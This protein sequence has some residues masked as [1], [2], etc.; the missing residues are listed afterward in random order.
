MATEVFVVANKNTHLAT[1]HFS[2]GKVQGNTGCNYF[3]A[4]Y[5][6]N[7]QELRFGLPRTTRKVCAE[8]GYMEQEQ[9][10][11]QALVNTARYELKA[12]KL[13]LRDNKGSL[14]V[15]FQ[16]QKE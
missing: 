1:I 10:Y 13:N 9:Q 8:D 5:E 14:M 12:G 16:K 7:D 11:L 3:S 6:V 4:S 15:A 2:Q